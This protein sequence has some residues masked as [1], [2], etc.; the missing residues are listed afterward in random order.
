MTPTDVILLLHESSV[1]SFVMLTHCRMVARKAKYY[2][3]GQH[4]RMKQQQ[5]RANVWGFAVVLVSLF[6]CSSS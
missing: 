4:N 1:P 6:V 3:C 2:A 5:E